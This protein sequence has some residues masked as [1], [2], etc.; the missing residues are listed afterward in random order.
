MN[1]K[2]NAAAIAKL[3]GAIDESFKATVEAYADNCKEAIEAPIWDW[4]GATTY[5]KNGEIVTQPRNIVDTRELIDSQQPPRI[6]GDRA[7]I[8]WTAK[9]ATIAHEGLVDQ[10]VYPGRPWTEE[11]ARNTD[12]EGIMADNL[13]RK[14][15]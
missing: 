8:E 9:H 15:K 6:E 13:R 14:L 4:T 7:T 3:N 2:L 11:A 5:R 1:I 12:F 10:S